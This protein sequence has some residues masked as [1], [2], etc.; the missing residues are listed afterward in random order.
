MSS[1]TRPPAPLRAL[2]PFAI[3]IALA[4]RLVGAPAPGV[5]PGAAF[6]G[7]LVS[8]VLLAVAAAA[9]GLALSPARRPFP[10]LL[11]AGFLLGG[12]PRALPPD[13]VFARALDEG[14]P[15][16]VAG[17]VERFDPSPDGGGR[18]WLAVG[19]RLDS[20]GAR[21]AGG[22]FLVR[23]PEEEE[24]LREGESLVVALRLLPLVGPRNPGEW[25]G[26]RHFRRRGVDGRAV[27]DGDDAIRVRRP[28][29]FLS[30]STALHGL[31]G[32]MGR[33]IDRRLDG[34]PRRFA[35]VL[36][37][38]DRVAFLPEEEAAFRT[39]GVTHVL[40]VSGLHVGLVAAT[41]A[42][43]TGRART[44]QGLGLSLGAVWLYTLIVGAPAA[45]VRSAAMLSLG[46]L[47][48]FA[49]R[50]TSAAGVLSGAAL[51]VLAGAPALLFDLG[52]LLSCLSIA[53][54]LVA[55]RLVE[56]LP[57]FAAWP[58]PCRVGTQVFGL[59]FG[60][61]AATASITIPIWGDWPLVAPVA[62]LLVVGLSDVILTGGFLA[63]ALDLFDPRF[64]DRVFAV[65]WALGRLLDVLVDQ[66]AARSPGVSGLLP[67]PPWVPW[68]LVGVAAVLLVAHASGARRRVLVAG[69]AVWIVLFALLVAWPERVPGRLSVTMLDIG[70]GDALLVEFPDGRTLLV[71][72]GEG[73]RRQTGRRVVLP[74]LRAARQRTIDALVV[75]HA[76]HD[77][78]GGLLE[79]LEAG[80]VA[81]VYDSGLG[82]DRGEPRRFAELA[83]ATGVPPCLVAAGDT[84]LAGRDYAVTVLWPPRPDDPHDDYVR[85]GHDVNNLSLVLLV[86]CRGRRIVLTGDLEAPG[87]AALLER[88]PAGPIDLLKVGHHGS[89]TSTTPPFLDRLAPRLAAV[90]VGERN[91]FR[92]PS[93]IVM[94]RLAKSGAR[95]HRTDTGG[96]ARWT[97]DEAGALEESWGDGRTRGYERRRLTPLP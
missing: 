1:G 13:G 50:R 31:R 51:V 97:F 12:L 63:L 45:A 36:L 75:S 55:G 89:I 77:H 20:A 35:R 67:P 82:P 73:G 48:R 6:A 68:G 86:E 21:R 30:L 84:L 80:R 78:Q 88:L 7:F 94:E 76:H 3:G 58:K 74:A 96:A 53:G 23:W 70:Q 79:A 4:D 9:V 60:A 87:E 81:R 66:L 27:L 92:H 40:S 56:S 17:R 69:G 54:L 16:V 42:L 59:T 65:V 14:A 95:V 57:N 2:L 28:P 44:L 32:E 64:A 62:N 11:A 37:L 18:A 34:F 93:R 15:I 24:P 47:A 26:R 52:F 72:G 43:L 85:D 90:S 61:Q 71:D 8:G 19:A 46:L 91:K 41:V 22:R 38:G 33:S 10:A 49:R 83:V 25:E 29:P 39:A 5:T